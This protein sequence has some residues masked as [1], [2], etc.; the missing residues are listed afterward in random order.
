[1]NPPTQ[2]KP[3]E[4]FVN[5]DDDSFMDSIRKANLPWVKS[6]SRADGQ[7]PFDFTISPSG[8]SQF[9]GLVNAADAPRMHVRLA[10]ANVGLPD[11]TDESPELQ[12]FGARF[13]LTNDGGA[14]LHIRG[15]N[16]LEMNAT[17][18]NRHQ[19]A[20]VEIPPSQKVQLAPSLVGVMRDNNVLVRWSAP[21]CQEQFLYRYDYLSNAKISRMALKTPY[22][23]PD[24][25]AVSS[26]AK[27]IVLYGWL[28]QSPAKPPRLNMVNVSATSATVQ[29][30]TGDLPADVMDVT[31][32]DHG[33][34]AFSPNGKSVAMVLE[35][36]DNAKVMAWSTT[37]ST[38]NPLLVHLTWKEPCK[39][40]GPAAD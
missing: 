6:V 24:I 35:Q 25:C 34:I 30:R 15:N 23:S 22:T 38:V 39:S 16:Q 7:V 5:P 9:I 28:S 1:V 18:E 27:D 8:Q 33:E 11:I 12:T 32:Y 17:A 14:I 10:P 37:S 2:S 26:N 13:L 29:T 21:Q 40:D 20:A 31:V 36:G 3:P 4:V 19:T